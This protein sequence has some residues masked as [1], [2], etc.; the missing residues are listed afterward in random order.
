MNEHPQN[1]PDDVHALLARV[2][3]FAEARDL[4]VA[5]RTGRILGVRRGEEIEA[6]RAAANAGVVPKVLYAEPSGHLITPFLAQ[7]D[8]L[9]VC[10]GLLVCRAAGRFVFA[11]LTRVDARDTIRRLQRQGMF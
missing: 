4:R 9:R 8:S 5:A 11:V 2:P 6:A 7:A 3:L 1:L 10:F